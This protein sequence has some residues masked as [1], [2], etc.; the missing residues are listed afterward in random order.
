MF[1]KIVER[2]NASSK[3]F[4]LVPPCTMGL[5]LVRRP[6]MLLGLLAAESESWSLPFSLGDYCQV[7]FVVALALCALLARHRPLWSRGNT[8]L[9]STLAMSLG[10]ALAAC[11]RHEPFLLGS[12]LLVMW[13]AGFLFGLWIELLASF[14]TRE[15]A[16]AYFGS[17]L[18]NIAF[19]YLLEGCARTVTAVALILCPLTCA[20]LYALSVSAMGRGH[21]PN[22]HLKAHVNIPAMRLL[23][24]IAVFS[25][26]YGLGEAVTGVRTSASG[27]AALGRVCVALFFCVFVIFFSKK[28]SL[29]VV[30]RAALPLACAG[31]SITFFS[32]AETFAGRMLSAAGL[33]CYQALA[34]ITCCGISKQSG[35]SAAFPCC[36]V[37]AV[38][39]LLIGIGRLAPLAGMP[40]G[41][42]D[43]TAIGVSVVIALV[44]ATTCLYGERDFLA[45]YSE[46]SLGGIRK[47]G[48]LR[49]RLAG[50]VAERGLT[51]READ[52]LTLLAVGKSSGEIADALFISSSTVRV[53]T[54]RIYQKLGVR[55]HEELE[56]LVAPLL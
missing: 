11:S 34:I 14:D 18:L 3:S 26:A 32:G 46:A 51:D 4:V 50:I 29:G 19:V 35:C 13:G 55:G 16:A 1:W 24:W 49:S 2:F 28:F 20:V 40:A 45:S 54:S 41:G 48:D 38:E 52:V 25:L 15:T 23:C 5:F 33:E 9:A 39:S 22:P 47:Q 8:I 31:L 6:S 53:H 21:L 27:A 42:F 7:A 37:F 44:A 30:Y 17:L 56:R 12:V 36:G 10:M 43:A